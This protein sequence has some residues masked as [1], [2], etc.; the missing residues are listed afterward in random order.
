MARVMIALLMVLA[1]GCSSLSYYS[2]SIAG[3]IEILSQRRPIA[4]ILEDPHAPEWTKSALAFVTEIRS[5]AQDR[6]L[7]P[8]NGSYRSFVEL[9]RPYVAWNVFATPAL[10]LEPLRWCYPFA[11]CLS[12]RGYFSEREARA[13]ARELESR[14]LDVFV[15]GVVAY[16]TLGWFADPVLDTMTRRGNLELAKVIFHELA[17]QRL[18]IEGETDFNEAFA[19]AVAL[20]GVR[21]WFSGRLGP[22]YEAFQRDQQTEDRFTSLMLD[23]KSRLEN[24]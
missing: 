14:G 10:S 18:Y 4:D 6:L 19:D 13:Y 9:G 12:Y 23:Y 11:G 20:I 15:G 8:D 22:E 2:Q 16:S 17:H 24:L 3:Q 1:G 7:L 21:L 5:F